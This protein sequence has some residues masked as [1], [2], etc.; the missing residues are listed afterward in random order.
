MNGARSNPHT[1][2]HS[3]FRDLQQ[4]V[5][6]KRAKG[7]SISLCIPTLNEETT[8][9]HIVSVFRSTLMEEH[10]IVDE[11]AVVD[12]GSTD[13]TR[14]IA[15]SEGADVYLADTILP[16]LGASRGKGENLWK[17]IHQLRGDIICFVDGDIRN[18]HPKFVYGL[19]GPL[20]MND[21]LA[22]VKAF[23]DRTHR[24]LDG[25]KPTGG[26]R[27]TEV[28]VR[29]LLSLF[30]PNLCGIFQPLAGE[31]AARRSVLERLSFPTG[32]GVETAHLL[33]IY[34]LYGI[35]AL[36]Q[37]DLDERIH[38]HRSNAELGRMAFGI[39]KVF[40]RRINQTHG[41]DMDGL[42]ENILRQVEFED[43]ACRMVTHTI[44][45][46]ERPPMLEIKQYLKKFYPSRPPVEA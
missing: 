12:S 43:G 39:L 36:A 46:E 23:Y 37:T 18:M 20:L 44:A 11:I 3:T 10:A 35:E 21:G 42:S 34:R 32:Y 31:Y 33:D 14:E 27:V 24:I 41:L 22:Y 26:G 15:A 38:R 40:L 19:I 6:A 29:P 8:V 30:Y 4:L 7:L 9:G 1:F 2:H 45:E 5:A 25:E 28:L 16:E 17:S 13:R